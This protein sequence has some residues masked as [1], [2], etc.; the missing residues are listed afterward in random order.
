MNTGGVIG[1]ILEYQ[2]VALY[3]NLARACL[4]E[5]TQMTPLMWLIG[6]AW[7]VLFFVVGFIVFWSAE[8]QYGR[9]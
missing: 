7:S 3:L 1:L 4:M 9:D 6:A 8:H 5:E 2:P